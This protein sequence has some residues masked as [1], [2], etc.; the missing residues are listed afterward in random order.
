[1]KLSFISTG[2]G[3]RAPGPLRAGRRDGRRSASPSSARSSSAMT[4]WCSSIRASAPASQRTSNRSPHRG[5]WFFSKAVMR[6]EFEPSRDALVNQLPALG[7][8]PADVKHA[9]LSH[10]H[11]D[12]AGRHAR[13]PTAT[14]SSVNRRE[15]EDA[16]SRKGIACRRL[17]Q[18]RVR[19]SGPGHAV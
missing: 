17:H 5:N 6:T 7:I 1:M 4:G 19:G 13:P 16:T 2:Y 12:H 14:A 9:V 11:W 10:L 3:K 18:G 15:W 8:D